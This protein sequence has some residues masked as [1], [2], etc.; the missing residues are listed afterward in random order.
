VELELMSD[1][2]KH[3]CMDDNVKIVLQESMHDAG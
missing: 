3:T 2:D 1:Y